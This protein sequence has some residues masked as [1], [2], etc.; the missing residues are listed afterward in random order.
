[1]A[2]CL[3]MFLASNPCWVSASSFFFG[4]KKRA[5]CVG[6]AVYLAGEGDA[7]VSQPGVGLWRM[8][9]AVRARLLLFLVLFWSDVSYVVA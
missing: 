4:S 7:V 5:L 3:R 8:A 6:L 9:A 1:M 2:V